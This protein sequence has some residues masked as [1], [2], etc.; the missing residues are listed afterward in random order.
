[1]LP[2]PRKLKGVYCFIT[3]PIKSYPPVSPSPEQGRSDKPSY[4]SLREQPSPSQLVYLPCLGYRRGRWCNGFWW[5]T[6]ATPPKWPSS[7][8]RIPHSSSI[9]KPISK[10]LSCATHRLYRMS[11][12]PASKWSLLS[13]LTQNFLNEVKVIPARIQGV[14]LERV[15]WSSLR[16]SFEVSQI[17]QSQWQLLVSTRLENTFQRFLSPSVNSCLLADS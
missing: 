2:C 17:L 11:S 4:F 1:M 16:W 10:R 15:G 8:V 6:Q 12:S 7:L 14:L 9:P 13:P 3:Q 5:M